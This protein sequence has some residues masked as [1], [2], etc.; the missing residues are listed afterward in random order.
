MRF[1]ICFLANSEEP[2]FE[3]DEGD[4]EGGRFFGGGTSEVQDVSDV[5]ERSLVPND[6]SEQ[7]HFTDNS[8]H[9]SQR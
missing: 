4:D 3:A 8:G 7:P 6:L 5:H 1:G 2:T 9:P